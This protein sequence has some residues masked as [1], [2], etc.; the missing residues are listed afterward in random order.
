MALNVSA[1]Q[2]IL[3][4]DYHAPIVDQLENVSAF[5]AR[6]ERHTSETGGNEFYIPLRT[7]RTSSIGARNDDATELLPKGATPKYS[8]VTYSAKALYATMRITGRAIRASRSPA[9]AFAKAQVRDMEDTVK[10]LRKDVNR[11]LFG[12]ADAELAT[13]AEAGAT[14]TITIG[15][16][17][18]PTNPAK[19]LYAGLKVDIKVRNNL[20]VASDSNEIASV[21]SS[22]EITLTT[23]YTAAT[24]QS[25][26]REDNTKDGSPGTIKEVSGLNAVIDDRDPND[27]WGTDYSDAYL[28]G[29]VSRDIAGNEFWKANRMHNSGTLRTF[30]LALI[31]EGIDESEIQAGGV[32]T[33][34]QTNHAIKRIYGL[35]MATIKGADVGEME[36]D[37][38]F[39][40]L[41]VNGIPMVWDVECPDYH[42]YLIDE[43]SFELGVMG[44][45][46]WI[47]NDGNGSVLTRLPQQDQFEAVMV[48]DL[49][50]ICNKPKA[51]VKI[52]DVD[53]S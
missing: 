2:S 17:A 35:Q 15:S 13:V 11:Q 52:M 41:S 1:F 10:D 43:D 44:P 51:N 25:I 16:N 47:E 6:M 26:Y 19:F 49:Q 48:R 37:G 20:S 30:A 12:T 24:T 42:I 53:H 3:K 14:A 28:V 34:I 29:S 23:S 50:L 18:Y 5:L 39:K 4:T 8:N 36:L 33:L 7:G 45:W 22:T 21:N 38:G 27:I 46:Q 9:Y 32:I 40:A 31:Q